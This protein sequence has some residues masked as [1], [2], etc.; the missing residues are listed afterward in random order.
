M[1]VPQQHIDLCRALTPDF[2]EQEFLGR[3]LFAGAHLPADQVPE[4][5]WYMP[6]QALAV[7]L[8]ATHNGPVHRP[9]MIVAVAPNYIDHAQQRHLAS[10]AGQL[11]LEAMSQAELSRDAVYYTTVTRFPMPQNSNTYRQQW[12]NTGWQ[13]VL[14][15]IELVKPRAILFLGS[16][17]TKLAF[18]KKAKL[19]DV[20]GQ[21]LTFQGLSHSCPAM[22]ANSHM[23]F[24]SNA[25][26]LGILAKQIRFFR[27]IPLGNAQ[28]LDGLNYPD[29][30]YKVLWDLDEI[31]KEIANEVTSGYTRFAIDVETATDTGHPEDDYIISFQWS[32]GPGH[33]RV[34]PLLI[35][36]P[37]KDVPDVHTAGKD[38]GKVKTRQVSRWVVDLP[39]PDDNT[40]VIKDPVT[41]FL[42][43]V[44][45]EIAL[46]PE[47]G[48]SGVSSKSASDRVA[49]WEAAVD[50]IKY[51]LTWCDATCLM[52]HNLRYDLASLHNC[53]GLEV[54][55]FC[56]DRRSW[57]TML[58]CHLLGKEDAYG[59]KE[60][61]L[62]HTD[63]GAYDA[64]MHAWVTENSG[65]GKLFPGDAEERFFFGF[66]DIAYK[67]LLPY[68]MCDV[69][70]TFRLYHRFSAELDQPGNEKVRQIFYEIELPLQHAL[71]DIERNGM[72]ADEE[73]LTEL[74]DLYRDKY[75]S[76]LEELREKA[77]WPDL[78]INSPQ[79]LQALLY[80]GPFKG[81]EKIEAKLPAGC[82]RMGLTP[83]LTTGK[84]PRKWAE[85]VARRQESYHAPS[86]NITT[87]QQLQTS[88]QLDPKQKEILHL[89]IQLS[90]MKQFIQLFLCEPNY[91]TPRPTGRPYYG[92]GL[93]GCINRRGRVCTSIS[94]LSETG[95]WKHSKPNLA[96]LP[97]NKE[98]N[99]EKIMGHK[100][101]MVRSGFKAPEGWVIMETDYCSAELF[102][103]GYMS[104]DPGFIEVL[105]SG[106]DVHG[107]NAVKVF[108]LDCTP[109]EVKKKYKDKRAA[110][111]TVVFGLI[112]GLSP[113][114]LADK[115]TVE[116]GRPV[117]VEEAQ[118]IIDQF[119]QTYP[120]IKRFIDESRSACITQGYVETAFGRRRYFPGVAALGADKQAAAKRE[121]TNAR[122]QGTVADL[123]NVASINLDR[124]RYET[125][126][127]RLIGWEYTVA[128]H[129]AILVLVRKEHVQIMAQILRY[130]MSETVPIPGT[131]GRRL[132]IDAQCGDRWQEFEEVEIPHAA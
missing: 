81:I 31:R 116:L 118:A 114:G 96:N 106:Q 5:Q 92:K 6:G 69:D 131:G 32:H 110:V 85:I 113:Q 39:P 45:E 128:I 20:R 78:N 95:R 75:Q 119:F 111:K 50:L 12:L 63:M 83:I 120:G 82:Y 127:G 11:L 59:L 105:E 44:D 52:G 102:I 46:V 14:E 49:H 61:T 101:P 107:Y 122:I 55:Q 72:P 74:G 28:A 36:R 54:R 115:L 34:I 73:R 21:V 103:V 126:I 13:Y 43:W 109:D 79:Q 125:E 16:E 80:R 132:S 41:G 15:E 86:A 93:R 90:E 35:E 121:A 47:F 65:A 123:L 23:A 37:E 112:Y 108:K 22:A 62:K 57:D 100:I 99:I 2:N 19:E 60:Q 104:G 24:V 91:E 27:N 38:R 68:A 26:G 8:S 40:P 51:L 17:P 97:K 130:C 30:D 117:P 87:M 7:N 71:I 67:Y 48:G 77:N 129:D 29:R 53:F 88:Y 70:A 10:P 4:T 124:M 56:N 25:A 18:G 42:Y 98:G 33:A 3:M 89:V 58:A 84:Y 76:L 94:V 1:P 9:Y 66:R 64:P